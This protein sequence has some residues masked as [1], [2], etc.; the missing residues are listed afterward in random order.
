MKEREGESVCCE[1]EKEIDRKRRSIYV[2]VCFLDNE[3]ESVCVFVV[4]E[5]KRE[6]MCF[7]VC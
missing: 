1:A 5:R 4:K 2:F 7:R 6:S 3:R